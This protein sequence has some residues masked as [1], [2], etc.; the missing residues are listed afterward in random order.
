MSIWERMPLGLWKGQTVAVLASG[1][2][3]SPAV[4]DAVRAAGLLAI[5]VNNTVQLAPWAEMLYA[6]DEEWWWHPSSPHKAFA[7]IKASVAQVPGV[8]RLVITGS[9]GFDPEPGHIRTGGNSG[10]QA[11]H[12]AAQL[13]A[14][15]ILLCGFDMRGDSGADHWHGHHAHGLRETG[16][17]TYAR[18]R[19]NFATLVQPLAALGVQVINCTPGSALQWFPFM[20]LEAALAPCTEPA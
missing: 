9:T 4:A 15:R 14:A 3:M 12:I 17:G 13:G 10:Y 1:P 19:D 6:A 2:S 5:A 16:P 11:V 7:G 8:Q 20:T 18:W